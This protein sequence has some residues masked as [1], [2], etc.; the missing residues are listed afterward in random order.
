MKSLIVARKLIFR[1][2]FSVVHDFLRHVSRNFYWYV[3][4]WQMETISWK[5]FHLSL[6]DI[7]SFLIV[8]W[9]TT[10]DQHLLFKKDFIIQ[11]DYGCMHAFWSYNDRPAEIRYRRGNLSRCFFFQRL[12]VCS[13]GHLVII[14]FYVTYSWT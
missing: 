13:K 1:E 6:I 10:K 8:V 14:F 5:S 11:I 9:V 2:S 3:I 12:V 7:L 4:A